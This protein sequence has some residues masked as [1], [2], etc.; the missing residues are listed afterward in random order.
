MI[1]DGV[2][3]AWGCG[4]AISSFGAQSLMFGP[5]GMVVVTTAGAVS[6]AIEGSTQGIIGCTIDD[7]TH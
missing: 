6:G 1:A 2:G 3:A 7:V 4:V 5:T